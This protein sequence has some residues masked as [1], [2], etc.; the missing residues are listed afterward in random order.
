M[1][2][3]RPRGGGEK[4]ARPLRTSGCGAL[5]FGVGVLWDGFKKA[6]V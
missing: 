1:R 5:R 6:V 3:P 2:R 4:S